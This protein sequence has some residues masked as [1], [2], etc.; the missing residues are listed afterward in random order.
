MKRAPRSTCP[1][2]FCVDTFGDRWTLLII[3]DLAVF[4]KRNFSEL[5]DSD[6]QISTNILTD[7]LRHLQDRGLIERRVDPANRRKAIYKLTPMGLDLAPMITEMMLWAARHDD[8][9]AVSDAFVAKI[10]RDKQAFIKQL[11]K[12]A[13]AD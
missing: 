1:I 7:R 5:L 3:R 4:H 9:T 8:Q 11:K 12:S 6:E 2:E 13:N 10:K